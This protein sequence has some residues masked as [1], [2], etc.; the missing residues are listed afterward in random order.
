MISRL[1][2]LI[3]LFSRVFAQDDDA[4][5]TV[6]GINYGS[7]TKLMTITTPTGTATSTPT[8]SSAST[9]IN[10]NTAP[11]ASSTHITRIVILIVTAVVCIPCGLILRRYR[12]QGY[13][14]RPPKKPERKPND[15]HLGIAELP[16]GR[17][18]E[19]TELMVEDSPGE[20]G[21]GG[22]HEML[23]MEGSLLQPKE[24]PATGSTCMKWGTTS[25]EIQGF[26]RK[27]GSMVVLPC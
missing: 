2:G 18:H 3:W 20:M 25:P 11:S 4:S 17:Y 27:R 6:I 9:N 15:T 10:T 23:E 26:E 16:Q 24:M 8:R 22:H 21:L 14:F 13:F 12:R 1:L 5:P 19:T 7:T